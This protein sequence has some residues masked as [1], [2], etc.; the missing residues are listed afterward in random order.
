MY[1]KDV[2]SAS[3]AQSGLLAKRIREGDPVGR[4]RPPLVPTTT[5][6]RARAHQ[7]SCLTDDVTSAG[8]AR[9]TP[10]YSPS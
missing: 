4:Q 1:Q 2:W 10:M 5:Q 8:E 7:E 3:S 9:L 6:A